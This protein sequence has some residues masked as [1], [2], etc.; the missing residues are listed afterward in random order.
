VIPPLVAELARQARRFGALV[1]V[2]ECSNGSDHV[3][4]FDAPDVLSI[5][6][7]DAGYRVSLYRADCWYWCAA[8]VDGERQTDRPGAAPPEDV[9]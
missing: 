4:I 6:L 9:P 2:R 7:W 3:D 1:F 8:L 5:P